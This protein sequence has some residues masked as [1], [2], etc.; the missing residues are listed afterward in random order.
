VHDREEI[1]ADE[2]RHHRG[3][4]RVEEVGVVGEGL[5]RRLTDGQACPSWIMLTTGV[6]VGPETGR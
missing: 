5:D 6:A 4:G 1:V 2:A 3:A